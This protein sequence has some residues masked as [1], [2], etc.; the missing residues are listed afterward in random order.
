[1]RAVIVGNTAIETV[2]SFALRQ[3]CTTLFLPR[4]VFLREFLYLKDTLPRS[5][6][7]E[8]DSNNPLMQPTSG[9]NFDKRKK[10]WN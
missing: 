8:H 7:N 4:M 5:S 9:A 3:C 10:S 1:M 2:P 6:T